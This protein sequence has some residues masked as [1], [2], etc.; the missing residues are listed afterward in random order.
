MSVAC[1]RVIGVRDRDRDRKFLTPLVSLSLT[2]CAVFGEW[3]LDVVE[4]FA[5]A[6]AFGPQKTGSR[7]N[8]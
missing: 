6:A 8:L 5:E 7:D 4:S 3:W 2:F 1:S